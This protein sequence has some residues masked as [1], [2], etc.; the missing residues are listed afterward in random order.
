MARTFKYKNSQ[1]ED[2][3]Y[4]AII[5]KKTATRLNNFCKTFNINRKKFVE[6]AVAEALE[7]AFE[8][9][10]NK[11]SKEELIRLTMASAGEQSVLDDYSQER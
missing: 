9:E 10:L 7:G 11:L 4:S 6:N 8:R 3:T 1:S 5:S 2:G